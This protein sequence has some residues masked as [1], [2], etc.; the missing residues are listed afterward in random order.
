[1][2]MICEY[3]VYAMVNLVCVFDIYFNT[4]LFCKFGWK[5]CWSFD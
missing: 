2:P 5:R 4:T 1:M 3:I